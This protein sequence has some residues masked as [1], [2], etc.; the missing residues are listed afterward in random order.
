MC[1]KVFVPNSAADPEE[2]GLSLADLVVRLLEALEPPAPQDPDAAA[3]RAPKRPRKSGVARLDFVLVDLKHGSYNARSV[4]GEVVAVRGA[5]LDGEV[6]RIERLGVKVVDALLVR[7]GSHGG[8]LLDGRLLAD[9]L[10]S[11]C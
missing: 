3:E 11:F 8:S 2:A 9:A 7:E 10:A 5:E 1:P 6:Q 4:A